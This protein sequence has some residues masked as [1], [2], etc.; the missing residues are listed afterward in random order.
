MS[1]AVLKDDL[2]AHKNP[3]GTLSWAPTPQDPTQGPI[4]QAGYHGNRAEIVAWGFPTAAEAVQAWM[5][6]DEASQWGHRNNILNCE[7]DWAGTDH[8]TG[9]TEGHYWT[10]DFGNP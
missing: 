3:G 2:N 1:D 6:D 9:G 10:V 5:Q 8:Y 4:Y 7:L